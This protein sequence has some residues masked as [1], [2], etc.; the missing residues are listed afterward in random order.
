MDAATRLRCEA[1]CRTLE[2]AIAELDACGLEHFA[3]HA[4]HCLESVR[5]QLRRAALDRSPGGRERPQ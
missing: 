3:T 4:H 1:A 2:E 5:E